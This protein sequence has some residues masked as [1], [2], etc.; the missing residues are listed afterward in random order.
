MIRTKGNVFTGNQASYLLRK[1]ADNSAEI[2]RRP[3]CRPA[4][5]KNA[6]IMTPFARTEWTL[7]ACSHISVLRVLP[8]VFCRNKGYAR[9]DGKRYTSCTPV[10]TRR[11]FRRLEQEDRKSVV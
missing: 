9:R 11:G 3:A 1:R 7:H 6:E 10:E 5:Y 2:K 4:G 8:R